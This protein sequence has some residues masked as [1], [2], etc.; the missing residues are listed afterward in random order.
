MIGK[1][2][3]VRKR[4]VLVSPEILPYRL[5]VRCYA[6]IENASRPGS[7]DLPGLVFF[8]RPSIAHQLLN[9]TNETW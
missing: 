4:R 9:E 7:R 1:S 3:P 8:R 6:A 5:T 2:A